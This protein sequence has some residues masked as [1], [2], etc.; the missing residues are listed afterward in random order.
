[1]QLSACTSILVFKLLF[2]LFCFFNGGLLEG[3][4]ICFDLIKGT[5]IFPSLR[6]TL[7]MATHTRS[8][9]ALW[10]CSLCTKQRKAKCKL[11][12]L[13]VTLHNLIRFKLGKVSINIDFCTTYLCDESTLFLSVQ[14]PCTDWGIS[15]FYFESNPFFLPCHVWTPQFSVCR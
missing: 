13:V 1:M 8:S 15:C 2:F 11:W 6:H 4:C 14:L 10:G 9:I 7:N 3:C 12:I 5:V